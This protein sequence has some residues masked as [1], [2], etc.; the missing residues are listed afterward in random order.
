LSK[1]T[2]G[3]ARHGK[4][5]QLDAARVDSSIREPVCV[6][7]PHDLHNTHIAASNRPIAPYMA[8]VQT[9]PT[10][11]RPNARRTPK[12]C[13]E[14]SMTLLE[15]CSQKCE[16]PPHTTMDPP[17]TNMDQCSASY[18]LQPLAH[19]SLRCEKKWPASP[20]AY[21][22]RHAHP[23]RSNPPAIHTFLLPVQSSF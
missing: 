21:I 6:S 7:W 11:T 19:V 1:E 18:E 12:P 10:L 13:Q 15:P 23:V 22:P 14:W 5:S 3:R 4:L 9:G 8:S 20:L 16:S 2:G 17:G